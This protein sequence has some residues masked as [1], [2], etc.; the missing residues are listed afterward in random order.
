MCVNAAGQMV[1]PQT[2][3]AV[4][5]VEIAQSSLSNVGNAAASTQY[6]EAWCDEY[7][8]P[9][10]AA[11]PANINAPVYAT[12]DNTLTLAAPGSGFEARVGSLIGFDNGNA[13]VDFRGY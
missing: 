9:V 5:F 8:F 7:Y 11:T 4:A 3:G 2:A 12:D 6:V 1:R 13:I 10:P